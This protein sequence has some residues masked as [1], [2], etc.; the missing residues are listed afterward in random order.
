VAN[1][2]SIVS[3]I[4]L[5]ISVNWINGPNHAKKYSII[6]HWSDVYGMIRVIRRQ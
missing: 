2:T 4:D 6:W 3:A 5:R 1:G